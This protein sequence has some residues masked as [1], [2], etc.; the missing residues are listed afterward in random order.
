LLVV[1]AIIGI[2][3]GLL[4]PA[5]QKIRGLAAQ[6]SCTNNIRQLGLAALNCSVTHKRLPPLLGP[7]PSGKLA[8]GSIPGQYNGPPWGNT[9]YYLLPF[10]EQDNLQKASYETQALNGGSLLDPLFLTD[11]G[12]QPWFPWPL[13]PAPKNDL[14]DLM[15]AG[16]RTFLCP[17][18]PSAPSDGLGVMAL[19]PTLVTP[20]ITVYSDVAL[21]S[22]AANAQVFGK[23]DPTGL[24]FI[25]LDGKTRVQTDITDGASNTILF[26]E[27]LANVG[28]YNDD[29]LLGLPGGNSWA[30]W[31]IY[32]NNSIPPIPPPNLGATLLLD[33]PIPA[34]ALFSV[35][36]AAAPQIRPIS[37]KTNTQNRQPSSMHTG[38]IVVGLADGSART[39]SEGISWQ[40][41]WL[42]TTPSDGLPVPADW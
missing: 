28:L 11:L 1:I 37:F 21:T 42:A 16:V 8:Q 34:Y 24:T 36:Q 6:I 23:F 40:T 41:W 13:Y 29:P 7:F 9:F 12:Y 27:R 39:V 19:G 5:V 31:G 4:L 20:T 25:S 10:I 38:V 22:Y 35:G 26:T 15:H 14:P 30:W 18:D 33:T 3:I 32:S 17:G 2:L